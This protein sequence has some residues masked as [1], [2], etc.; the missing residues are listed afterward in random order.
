MKCIDPKCLATKKEITDYRNSKELE[1]AL[2]KIFNVLMSFEG[3]VY[4]ERAFYTSMLQEQNEH[5]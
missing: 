1:K 5:E 4:K 3:F 2:W